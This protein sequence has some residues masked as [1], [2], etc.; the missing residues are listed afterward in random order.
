LEL[1]AARA[2]FARLGAVPDLAGAESP[3]GVHAHGLTARELEV[4]RLVA[5]GKSNKAIA[6]ELVL[7]DRTVERH[8]RNIFTKLG[9]SSRTAA[10]AYAYEHRLVRT[11]DA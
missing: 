3:T 6:T 9:V 10:A 7:S 1:E 4:L 2:V 11:I 5:A 8:V